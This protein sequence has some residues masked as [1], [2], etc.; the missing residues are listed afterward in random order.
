MVKALLE[1]PCLPIFQAH[2]ARENLKSRQTKRTKA[3]QD[4]QQAIQQLAELTSKQTRLQTRL[5]EREARIDH[6][7]ETLNQLEQ[8][9]EQADAT[10]GEAES[11]LQNAQQAFD[12]ISEMRQK[13]EDSLQEHRQQTADLEKERKQALE[14]HATPHAGLA[15]IKAQQE[16]LEQADTHKRCSQQPVGCSCRTGDSL[17]RSP[18]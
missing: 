11:K 1:W 6:Q 16:V 15:R 7:K 4:I 13:A 12:R 2:Q 3:E 8:E 9:V 18:G 17:G 14:K 5:S 10:L